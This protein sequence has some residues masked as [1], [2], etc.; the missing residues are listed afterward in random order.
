MLLDLNKTPESDLII[1]HIAYRKRKGLYSLVLINGMPGTGKSSTCQRLAELVSIKLYGENKITK[2]NFVDSLLKL[3]EAIQN[4]QKNNKIIIIEEVSVLFSSRRSMSGEN[5]SIGKILDTARKK[6]LIIFAN[7][8]VF[9]T[10][11]T[12]IRSM[13]NILL[14]TLKVIKT[15][16][17]VV[18]KAWRVQTDP[19]TGKSYRHR[20]IRG[21]KDVSL[22]YT[23][24]GN[25]QVWQDY[26]ET[27][28][29]FIDTLYARLKSIA[30]KKEIKL[31]KEAG[32]GDGSRPLTARQ[33]QV[34]DCVYLDKLT[35][36]E[37]AAKIGTSLSN[38]GRV[39]TE[40]K[41]K[42]DIKAL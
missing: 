33:K 35:Y 2:H 31:Q 4:P 39:V 20:F 9:P 17:I 25:K 41:K 8:P 38:V 10:I 3:L 36:K 27:K 29:L 14:Q 19:H 5:V 26:E 16:G 32:L 13:C 15:S 30:E 42:V 24:R 12:N 11:D 1:N 28:D 23:K 21:D 18:S 34:F 22:F 40:I 7:A 37:A 6:E